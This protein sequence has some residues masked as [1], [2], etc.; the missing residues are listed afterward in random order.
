MSRKNHQAG[1][2]FVLNLEDP[3]VRLGYLA[4]LD[5]QP[6]PTRDALVRDTIINEYGLDVTEAEIILGAALLDLDEL[7][8]LPVT[9]G[10]DHSGD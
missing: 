3:S 5:K 6:G 4:V 9:T 8:R 10:D 2:V 1:E 7:E